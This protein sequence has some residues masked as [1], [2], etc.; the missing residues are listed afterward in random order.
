MSIKK[1]FAKFL[2]IFSV[3]SVSFCGIKDEYNGFFNGERKKTTTQNIK[4]AVHGLTLGS[5]FLF[6]GN[7]MR[8]QN[9]IVIST[10]GN[11]LIL[12]AGKAID[13]TGAFD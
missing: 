7:T 12:C 10:V 9:N 1:F 11:L 13:A 3:F 4:D 5:F 2:L 6:V 8:S